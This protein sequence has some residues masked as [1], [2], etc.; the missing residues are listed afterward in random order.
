MNKTERLLAIVLALQSQ[1]NRQADELAATFEVTTR[2]IYRDIEALCMAGVPIVSERGFGYSLVDGY[3]LPPLNF[4]LDEA[5]M[6]ILGA[7]F[8]AQSVDAAY[9]VAAQTAVQKIESVLPDRHRAQFAYLKSNLSFYTGYQGIS[10][11]KQERLNRL[12]Q[13]IIEQRC[14]EFAYTKRTESI[15]ELTA[16]KRTVAPYSLAWFIADWYLLGHCHLR[17]DMRVFR[18]SRIDKLMLTQTFFKRP[19]NFTPQWGNARGSD[20]PLRV[21]VLFSRE[22]APWLDE[23]PS[24]YITQIEQH[25]DGVMVTLHVRREEDILQW[26]FSWGNEAEVLEPASLRRQIALQAQRLVTKYASS[27]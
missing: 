6:L 17:Q 18:L 19:A 9:R 21:R 26:V 25:S 10:T 14:V 1:G 7:D 8:S 12:R 22:A 2:T 15:A 24:F 27:S 4:S 16:T 3:F 13:A 11:E 5:L 20:R 23:E